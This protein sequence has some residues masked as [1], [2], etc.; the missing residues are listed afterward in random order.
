LKKA[1]AMVLANAEEVRQ[2]LAPLRRQGRSIVTTN[3]CFDILHAGHIQYL[4]EAAG[5]GDILVVGINSDAVV[6]K[7]K[8]AGRPIQS[9]QDRATI[10][11]SLRIVDYAFVFHEDDPRAFLE[12]IRPDI[13]VKGGDY[14]A[15]IIEREVVE[16]HG[17]K[18]AIVSFRQGYSTTTVVERIRSV[19]TAPP[20]P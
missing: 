12:I 11:G 17:G 5:L 16:A 6:R 7:L 2:A 4:A 20:D 3:G 13:H 14:R 8:G 19:A 9:E 18:V 10:M 1:A 15:D